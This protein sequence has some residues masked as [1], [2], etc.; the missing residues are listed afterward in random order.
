MAPL[1]FPDPSSPMLGGVANRDMDTPVKKF[2]FIMGKHGRAADEN[3]L[4]STVSQQPA[5]R[6]LPHLG[7]SGGGVG[8]AMVD[9]NGTDSGVR[10][11]AQQQS[12]EWQSKIHRI[13]TEVV[14]GITALSRPTGSMLPGQASYI[15]MVAM[16][17]DARE[18]N[19]PPCSR[20][21]TT[22]NINPPAQSLD[23][24]LGSRLAA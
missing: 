2:S 1:N 12:T 4:A 16:V 22:Q 9:G 6:S 10:V 3:K 11:F 8:G 24:A 17:H 13:A 21:S 14:A 20:W 15:L 19:A 5:S 18:S 7:G 23:D